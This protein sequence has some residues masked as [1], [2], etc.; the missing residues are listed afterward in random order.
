MHS[1]SSATAS[2][3]KQTEAWKMGDNDLTPDLLTTVLKTE[4]D[5]GPLRLNQ[6]SIPVHSWKSSLSDGDMDTAIV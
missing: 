6:D 5:M 3:T 1:V 4:S 2:N